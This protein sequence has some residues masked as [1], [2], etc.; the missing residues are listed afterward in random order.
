MTKFGREMRGSTRINFEMRDSNDERPRNAFVEL[1]PLNQ[2]F[3]SFAEAS[4]A[5]AIGSRVPRRQ[6]HTGAKKISDSI[7]MTLNH[8]SL[9]VAMRPPASF[10]RAVVITA[11]SPDL[12]ALRAA[13]DADTNIVRYTDRAAMRALFSDGHPLRWPLPGE[14]RLPEL[15]RYPRNRGLATRGVDIRDIVRIPRHKWEALL[16]ENGPSQLDGQERSYLSSINM[17]STEPEIAIPLPTI[18]SAISTGDRL[19]Q[20]ISGESRRH[21]AQDP[22]LSKRVADL[23]AAWS[24]PSPGGRRW[25]IEDGRIPVELT[26]L[27]SDEVPAQR[28][29]MIDGDGAVPALLMSRPFAIWARALL[30]SATSWS[31]RFQVSQTFEAFPLTLSFAVSPAEDQS[32]PQLHFSRNGGQLSRLARLLEMEARPLAEVAHEGPRLNRA[33]RPSP[34]LQEIDSMLLADFGLGSEASDLDILERLV[35]RNQRHE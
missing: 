29:F 13:N 6:L 21:S 27:E 4:L 33:L 1:H 11:E 14:V 28:L 9:A 25:V 35:E 7:G 8:P 20:V 16:R 31:S 30:P 12:S 15:H 19:A 32:P 2:D 3:P 22:L 24:R 10:G 17:I 26:V 34:I 23:M 5:E 18:W